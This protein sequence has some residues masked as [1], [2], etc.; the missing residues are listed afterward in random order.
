MDR[1]HTPDTDLSIEGVNPA[2]FFSIEIPYS[3]V[4]SDGSTIR[5][6][7]DDGATGIVLAALPTGTPAK[8][9]GYDTQSAAIREALNRDVPVVI[10]Q[11]G[12]EG[13]PSSDYIADEELIWAD[14]L[15]P[16]K[17]RILLTLGLANLSGT[18]AL[19]ELFRRY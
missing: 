19:Q 17:S 13:W 6:A 10:S 4:G 16:Q 15:S 11:R 7:L 18:E 12:Y 1:R 3:A 8:A 5:R 9:E 2:D 14:T